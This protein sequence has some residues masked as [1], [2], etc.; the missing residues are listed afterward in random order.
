MSALD[1]AF[2]KA[3]SQQNPALAPASVETAKMAY[4]QTTTKLSPAMMDS[5]KPA[6]AATAAAES[7][8]SESAPAARKARAKRKPKTPGNL[9][10]ESLFESVKMLESSRKS[11]AKAAA[12]AKKSNAAKAEKKISESSVYNPPHSAKLGTPKKSKTEKTEMPAAHGLKTSNVNY[13]LDLPASNAA[14]SKTHQAV[15]APHVGAIHTNASEPP[16]HKGSTPHSGKSNAETKSPKNPSPAEAEVKPTK[17]FED[18]TRV[19]SNL[20]GGTS[21]KEVLEP[22]AKD[23]FD[24]FDTL[25]MGMKQPA[26]PQVA[27]AEKKIVREESPAPAKTALSTQSVA[28]ERQTAPV[29]NEVP[30]M[31]NAY[32]GKGDISD[33][34]NP[35][36]VK[37]EPREQRSPYPE[38]LDDSESNFAAETSRVEENPPA[39]SIRLF[40]PML[41]VDH[42]AWPKVCGRLEKGAN[43]ELERIIEIL[44]ASNERGKKMFALGGCRSGDGATSLLLATARH[45]AAQGIKVALVDADW[46]QPQLARRLGLLPQYGWEDVLSGRL[47]LEEVLIES[48]AERLVI[49]PVREPFSASELPADAPNRIAETWES[50]RH[51]F[52][53][54]LIDPGPISNSPILDPRYSAVMAGRIEAVVMVKNLRHP[55]DGEFQAAQQALTGA[56]A[57]VIGIVENFAE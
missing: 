10:S 32:Q 43:A 23:P 14:S 25:S 16:A 47:P 30:E 41:Q 20:D 24:I 12:R 35:Y 56:S 19:F 44:I 52:D 46:S 1:Q 42:F 11:A 31:K 15:P 48:L 33:K 9:A 39:P 34:Q 51:H 7:V 50:L 49:L 28:V 21:E 8:K 6:A 4:T 53:V 29:K 40:Q 5:A 13:R 54:V 26:A 2:I 37:T 22:A 36:A 27:V 18:I 55:D 45:M 17:S 3:Y 57:K 38:K